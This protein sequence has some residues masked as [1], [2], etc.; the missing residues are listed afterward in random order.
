M[1]LLKSWP[2]AQAPV[3][4]APL[5]C[6]AA[7]EAEVV[8]AEQKFGVAHFRFQRGSAHKVNTETRKAPE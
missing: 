5:V 7:A 2:S 6:R 3:V 1:R 8:E 4:R